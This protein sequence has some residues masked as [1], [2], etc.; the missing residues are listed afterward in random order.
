LSTRK[1]PD[2]RLR[3]KIL[4]I[5]QTSAEN[6]IRY[7]DLYLESGAVSDALDFYAKAAHTE[8]LEKIRQITFE[9]GDVFLF[10][11]V[12]KALHVE[13]D[14][15]DWKA[16][17]GRAIEHQYFSFARHALEIIND[18]EGIKALAGMMKAEEA[19]KGA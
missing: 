18:T 17:A 13:P 4:Y 9:N 6:L 16:I 15:S 19:E 10:Q 14:P 1:L 7:G 12:A 8:G 11:R 3:Q 2:Y 5:D